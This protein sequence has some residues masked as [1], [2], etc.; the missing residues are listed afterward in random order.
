M[1]GNE[2]E[3]IIFAVRAFICDHAK[4]KAFREA[5]APHLPDDIRAA[6]LALDSDVVAPAYRHAVLRYGSGAQTV[7]TRPVA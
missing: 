7:C 1:F 3:T 6:V 2:R 5:M 4:S